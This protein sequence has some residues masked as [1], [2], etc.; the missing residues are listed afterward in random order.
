MLFKIQFLQDL[1]RQKITI[2]I[3]DGNGEDD[4]PSIKV[5]KRWGFSEEQVLPARIVKGVNFGLHMS[6][7]DAHAAAEWLRIAAQTAE[8]LDELFKTRDDLKRPVNVKLVVRTV[9]ITFEQA[10]GGER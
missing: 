4:G 1:L 8:S 3:L 6:A 7:A 10:V 5:I 9:T 2:V